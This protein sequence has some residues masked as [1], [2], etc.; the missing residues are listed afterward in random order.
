MMRGDPT[1]GSVARVEADRRPDRWKC[2]KGGGGVLDINIPGSC[3]AG[4]TCAAVAA[5]NQAQIAAGTFPNPNATA[6]SCSGS[7]DCL[8]HETLAVPQNETGTYVV[9]GSIV[10]FTAADGTVSDLTVCVEGN[11]L[12]ILGTSTG[13]TGQTEVDSDA[14]AVRQ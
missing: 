13:A 10:T 14:V 5:A 12:H 8:C 4:T 9:A 11:H 2:R 3:F 7:S 6:I 1:D